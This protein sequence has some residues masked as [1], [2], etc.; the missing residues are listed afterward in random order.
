MN[1][2]TI[3]RLVGLFL[4][5]IGWGLA[6]TRQEASLQN[7]AT[8]PLIK[9]DYLVYSALIKTLPKSGIGVP[10][11]IYNKVT[12]C[13]ICIE[14]RHGIEESYLKKFPSIQL[15]T[16]QDFLNMNRSD[17]RSLLGEHFT[18][19][20]SYVLIQDVLL[21]YFERKQRFRELRDQYKGADNILLLSRIGFNRKRNQALLN[22]GFL[23]EWGG[24][25]N[26][27]YLRKRGG[28][29]HVIDTKTILTS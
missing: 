13:Q 1:R 29:W 19:P 22:I 5:I 25:W 9:D 20:Q 23:N 27:V 10:V 21:N 26:C 28:I 24:G 11:M 6:D 15:E 16:V 7:V 12:A 3:I 14:K 4:L 18:L 2:H 8:R 17:D